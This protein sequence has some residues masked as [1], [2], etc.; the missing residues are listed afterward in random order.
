MADEWSY[1]ELTTLTVDMARIPATADRMVSVAVRKTALDIEATA[2]AFCPVDT[3][4]LMNSIGSSP[5]GEM[6]ALQPGDMDAE[7][8]PTADYGAY[9]EFGTARRGPA[10][11]MGPALDR[12]AGDLETALNMLG[13]GLL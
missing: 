5:I 13:D 8:G 12:H 11:F 3:G 2:K 7:I 4:N 1:D 9:V 6:R 10:A